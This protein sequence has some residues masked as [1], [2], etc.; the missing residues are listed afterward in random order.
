M[1]VDGSEEVETLG[2][3]SQVSKLESVPVSLNKLKAEFVDG[4]HHFEP[5]YQQVVFHEN[6]S[7]LKGRVEK[8]EKKGELDFCCELWVKILYDFAFMYQ[9]WSRN[10]RRLVDIITPLYFGR[11]GAFCQQ[12]A[13]MDSS[14]A[15]DLIEKDARD[16]EKLKPYLVDKLKRWE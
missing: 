3:V 14:E 13:D 8:L 1:S 11:V 10:R 2:K 15:E 6:F 4:F 12:V 5:L 16:F 9:T 7:Q